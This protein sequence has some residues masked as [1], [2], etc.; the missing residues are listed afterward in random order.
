MW[1]SLAILWVALAAGCGVLPDK[2]DE[3]SNWSAQRLYT[4]AKQ[5]LDEG[6]FDQSVKMY[7][8]LEARYPYGRYAQ[9]AQIEVAYAYYRAGDR[10]Q[11][12]AACERFIRL[13]PNHPNVDYIFYLRGLVDFNEDMGFMS[14]ISRQDMTERDPKGLKDSFD[15]LKELVTRYPDSKYVPDATARMGYLVNALAASGGACGTLL[16]QARRLSVGRNA[17]AVRDQQLPA[18][19][20]DRRGALHPRQVLRTARSG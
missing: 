20:V 15:S 2:I 13:H 7:E 17:R 3:T 18:I 12:L 6:A 10:V 14:K 19:S 1:R 4:E 9:Q 8:K 5:L 11:A 16:L